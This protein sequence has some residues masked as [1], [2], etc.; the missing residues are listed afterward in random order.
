M[1]LLA[2]QIGLPPGLVGLRHEATHEDLPSLEVLRDGVWKA[3]EYLRVEAME[4]LVFY[5]NDSSLTGTT[6][7]LAAERRDEL[8]RSLEGSF[9][10]Y[11]K[12]IKTYFRERTSKAAAGSA[13]KEIRVIL[14]EIEDVVEKALVEEEASVNHI[15]DSVVLK[16]VVETLVQPGCLVPLSIK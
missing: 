16:V 5:E 11:K 1:S 3:L 7:R 10:H 4:P 13:S 2:R 15:Q 9:R 8:K 12:A 14:R 6:T